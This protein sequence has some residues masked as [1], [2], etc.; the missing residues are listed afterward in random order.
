[1]KVSLL[2][3]KITIQVAHTGTDDIG[4]Q[5]E[6]WRDVYTCYATVTQES[7][8][9][10]TSA[11]AVWDNSK[12]DFTI[13]YSSE[14]SRLNSTKYRILFNDT[15]YEIKGIDHLSYKKKAIK[16]HCQRVDR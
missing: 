8:L 9:E 10:E 6:G 5:M 4:N 3:T 12:T 11:G 15:L 1:M 13:R 16:L 14:V 7:P 2:N